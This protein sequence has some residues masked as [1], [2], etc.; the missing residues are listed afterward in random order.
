[1][2]LEHHTLGTEVLAQPTQTH[3]TDEFLGLLGDGT[4]AV[5]Q[6]TAERLDGLV[7]FQPVELAIE[8]HTLRGTGH[9]GLGEG[10]D[11]VA[12][13]LA[14]V[15]EILAAGDLARSHLLLEEFLEFLVLQFFDSLGKNLLVGLVA[16]V[17]DEAT[18][19][20]TQQVARTADVQILH[21]NVDAAAEVGEVLDGLQTP[22]GILRQ[23]TQRRGHEVAE[24]LLVRPPHATAHLMQVAETEVVGTT[25]ND[26]VGIGDIEAALDDGGGDEHIVVVGGKGHH[27]TLQLLGVHAA[28][29]HAH[30]RIG[31]ILMY[32]RLQLRQLGDAVVDDEDLPVA[33]HLEAHGLGNDLRREGMH[34]RL[35]GIAVGRRCLDDAE[36]PGAHEREL[37]GSGDGRGGERER[38]H[39]DLH[40]A[41]FLFRSDSE[42][43]FLV[44]DEQAEVLEFHSLADEFVGAHDDVNLARLEVSENLARLLGGAGPTEVIHAH[45]QVA[46]AVAEGVEVL[47]GKHGGGD[48][49]GCLLAIDGGL[50]GCAHGNL[51]LAEAHVAA[52]KAVHRTLT[53][54]V[55]LD[56]L[57][58]LELVGGVLVE[59][60]GFELV[61]EVGVGA[62][63][64]ALLL[65]AAGVEADEVAGDVLDL[66]LRALL[67]ALPGASSEA[68]DARRLTFLA[69]VLRDLVQS[70]DRDIDDIVVVKGDLDHLLHATIGLR[71]ADETAEAA[72]AVVNVDH[73]VTHLELLQFLQRE[74]HLARAGAVAAEVVLVEAVEDLM[75]CEEADLQVIISKSRVQGLVHGD[76]LHIGCL[77][78]EDGLQAVGLLS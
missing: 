72:D 52:D 44:D 43:L 26:G 69:L 27:H 13:Q 34:L 9:E 32:H 18:L 6:A 41:E 70:V 25:N 63:G 77:L 38:V 24:G 19:L 8:Q 14:L 55:G 67:H 40:L 59:E 65:A 78:L 73:V 23:G 54:H 66:R 57:R 12:L 35:N 60:A 3:H 22:T 4:E 64:E 5:L 58:G 37:Q 61:L 7:G 50:E 28:V 11:E 21:G 31:Y 2:V 39:I 10:H 1:M 45:G 53:L 20:G 51:G 16:E 47:V 74:C 71:H 17:G 48:H 68:A 30:T 42:F 56:V 49:D 15:H 36:V 62:V 33:A 46:Q 76:E 29:A 75:V